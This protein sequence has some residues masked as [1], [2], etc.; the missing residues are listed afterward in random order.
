MHTPRIN[1]P[2]TVWG[3]GLAQ[4]HTEDGVSGSAKPA[5]RYLPFQL[6]VPMSTQYLGQ[7]EKHIC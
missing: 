6:R 2:T 5:G 3:E 4:G 7:G 1:L